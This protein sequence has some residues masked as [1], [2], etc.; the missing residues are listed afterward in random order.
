MTERTATAIIN[1]DIEG[2]T[3]SRHLYGHFA[4]HL[5]HCVYGGFYVGE[6]SP[7]PNEG[8]IRLDVVEAL[9][10]LDIPNLRWPG[11]CFADEY[12]WRDGI[13]P[14]EGRPRMVNTHWGNV[15]ENNHFGTHEF[16]ALCELLGAEPYISGNIGSGTVQEMSEWVEYLTRDGDS[17]MV[18]LRKENGREEPW[19]VR[20]WGLG[21]E[22]WGCGGNMRAEYYADLARQYA[23]YC[24]DHGDNKLYRIASGAADDDYAWTETLMKQ[25]SCFGCEATPKN[26][27]QGLSFHYYTLAGP[28][29]A[30]GSATDFGVEDYYRTM[31]AARRVDRLI[32]G[33]SAV[34]DCYDPGRRVGLVLDEWGTWWDVEPGTNPGFLYQQNTLRDALVAS[35]HFD[36][37]HRHADRLVMAN[38]AQTVNVL[39]AMVL[40]DGE[41]LVKT[42]TYHVFEMNKRHQDATSL[43][44]HLRTA[45][46]RRPVGDGELETLSVSASVRDGEV[47]VSLT[48]LDAEQATEITLDLRGGVVGE[49][50]ARLLTADRLQA[51]NTGD[52]PEA[53]AA[54]PFDDVARTA[55]G[56]LRLTLPPH[57]FG[58]VAARLR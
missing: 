11:G 49:P 21:N 57:S 25:I 34:M 37:F 1:L 28:W 10:A 38:I 29:E 5:G 30:K 40:T 43:A 42:P 14:K 16:M 24:R 9:R 56:G 50:N 33:H 55:E 46:T 31:V 32:A 47:L 35:T 51:H 53:V 4:E 39:Q 15:E 58:T 2:P 23:T 20:F 6:D 17:P 36:V 7:I 8:G 54:R 22:T 45:G 12:H 48:N 19:R 27:F 13:G 18:R 44:V 52:D 3:I 26:F 41:R